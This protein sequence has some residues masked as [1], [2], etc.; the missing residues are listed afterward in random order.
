M[1][2]GYACVWHNGMQCNYLVQ[3]GSVQCA[4]CGLAAEFEYYGRFCSTY[5][6]VALIICLW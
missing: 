6:K 5:D 4:Q 2:Q 3:C 1:G